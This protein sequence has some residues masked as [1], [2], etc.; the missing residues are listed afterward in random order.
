MKNSI[1]IFLLGIF[2]TISIAATVPD[3]FMTIKPALPKYT[4]CSSGLY[5]Y[6][7]KNF[8]IKY[9]EKGYITKTCIGGDNT[10]VVIMEKY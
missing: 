1:L 10:I 3:S 8:I 4:V 6:E 9:T 2:V 5:P 7:V